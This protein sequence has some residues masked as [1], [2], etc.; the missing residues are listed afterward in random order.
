M[1]EILKKLKKCTYTIFLG[2]IL[3]LQKN[4]IDKSEASRTRKKCR[5][6]SLSRF[7]AHFPEMGTERAQIGH[8]EAIL[9]NTL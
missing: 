4:R 7:L 3:L 5:L 8:I 6:W 9:I 1:C 2:K